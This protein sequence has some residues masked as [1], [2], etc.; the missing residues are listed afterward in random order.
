M[1]TP[2]QSG[3][4]TGQ[5][6]GT[7]EG[8]NYTTD[9]AALTTAVQGVTAAIGT[10]TTL[11]D[12]KLWGSQAVGVPSSPIAILNNIHQDLSD[13]SDSLDEMQG[14]QTTMADSIS[15]V[16]SAVNAQ[17]A[18]QQRAS[19]MQQVALADQLQTNAVNRAESEAALKRAGI[20]PQAIP[21]FISLFKNSLNNAISMNPINELTGFIGEITDDVF[22]IA[23]DWMNEYATT[24][25]LESTVK[26]WFE[27]LEIVKAAKAAK[28]AAKVAAKNARIQA[29]NSRRPGTYVP[30]PPKLDS[31]IDV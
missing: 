9:I 1:A 29:R 12:N 31:P 26:E 22:G 21:D 7:F 3:R 23:T 20:E 16:Q 18:I 17:N 24:L 14:N 2:Y 4:V 25:Y 11:L 6:N 8:L 15:R 27:S 19:A 28:E 13:I 10:L 5:T 30:G